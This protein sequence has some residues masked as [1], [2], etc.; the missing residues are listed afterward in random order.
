[1]CRPYVCSLRVLKRTKQTTTTTATQCVAKRFAGEE[2]EKRSGRI[3]IESS[4]RS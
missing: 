3:V 4:H 2:G 1:M